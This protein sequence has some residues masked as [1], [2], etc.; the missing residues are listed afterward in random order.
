[1]Y[2]NKLICDILDYIDI[3]INKE[4]SIEELSNLFFFDRY[5]IMKL[6][7]KELNI[8]IINYIKSMRVYN[9]LKDYKY[10]NQ[11]I[12]IALNNGFNSLEYYSE[13][14][15]EIVKISPR[16]YKHFLKRNNKIS[17]DKIITTSISISNLQF[18]KDKAINYK[19]NRPPEKTKIKTLTIFK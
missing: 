18:I 11:I 12:R 5:Y 1:M 8:T 10:N 14:F 2:S 4:I 13:T 19:N 3:N 6:F 15:K 7:K 9:S 17:F 16:E